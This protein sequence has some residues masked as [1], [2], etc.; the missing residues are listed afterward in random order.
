[1]KQHLVYEL[2]HIDVEV[3]KVC[4]MLGPSPTCCANLLLC[5]CCWPV[6][7]AG[8]LFSIWSLLWVGPVVGRP[9]GA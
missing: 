9:A 6:R 2:F 5:C 3:I 8:L 1:M 7:Q 4:L